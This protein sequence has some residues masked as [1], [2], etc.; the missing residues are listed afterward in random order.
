M[1]DHPD[2]ATLCRTLN[3]ER[4]GCACQ[5]AARR[6]AGLVHCPAH[7][8]ERPS[9]SVRSANG[10]VLFHCQA[11]CDQEAV[12]EA[13]R[14]KGLWSD[15]PTHG[16]GLTLSELARAKR[17]PEE[18]LGALGVREGVHGVHRRP[19]VDIHYLD[20]AGEECA[21]QKRIALQGELRF[22]WR[23]GDRPIPYGLWR[24]NSAPPEAPLILVEGA[25]DAWTLWYAGLHALGLPGAATWRGDYAKLVA[26]REVFVWR[27]PDEGGA[28][29][30]ECVGRSLPEARVIEAPPDAKDPSALYVSGPAAFAERMGELMS[31][32]R[33]IRERIDAA[34]RA[35][36]EAAFTEGRELLEAPDLL[37]RIE[38]AVALSG[39]AGDA[40]PALL[41]YLAL[42]S[43]LLER[44]L[45]LAFVAIAA[46][47][48][49]R[50]VDAALDLMPASAYYLEKAGSP[51]ALVFND[52]DFQHRTVVVAEA[53]SIPEEG[54]AAS[55]IRALAA[56]NAMEYDVVE[57]DERTGHQVT[58]KI[59][60]P[61]PTGLITTSTKALGEQMGSRMLTVGIPDTPEQTRLV[62]RAHA[63]AATGARSALD[64]APF[65]AL[66]RWFELAA[67]RD[68]AVPFADLLA[69]RVPDREVRMRRDFAQL[70]TLIKALA[71]LRQR[72][73][74]RDE[75]GRVV[76]T[77]DDY[78]N[79]RAL[80][81]EVFTAAAT[82]GVSRTVRETV[83]ALVGAYDGN[84]PLTV[85]E[86]AKALGL[87]HNAARSRVREAVRLGYLHN[88]R[89]RPRQAAQLVPGDPL[90]E[91]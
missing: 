67:C 29:F 49:N 15:A 76:A 44:P 57:R 18:F 66:Q 84:T 1:N 4:T 54:P 11:G 36:A 42:T 21:V 83:A 30:A 31:S 62:L 35:E 52:E 73:R 58:R 90:P 86:L 64:R 14:E 60:K 3:C 9:L 81:L 70:L 77:L 53:D 89:T 23:R 26:G 63:A 50:A 33:P 40:R 43:R 48:K 91:D 19:C 20:A 22:L 2:A 56:D 13:L 5:G 80:L 45:N 12:L 55:A 88:L 51:R 10:R 87:S 27:E 41:A 34:S 7:A 25:S 65:V 61:G 69:D 16:V 38:R 82:G 17:L 32:A 28:A 78:A 6:G 8:D 46:S 68:I 72:Q 74:E 79:A 85:A 39:Y 75:Q 37:G 24:V 71:L 59:R 47:G